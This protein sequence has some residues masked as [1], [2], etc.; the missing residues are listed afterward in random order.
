MRKLLVLC[1]FLGVASAVQAETVH[2]VSDTLLTALRAGAGDRFKIVKMVPAGSAVTVLQVDEKSGYS[3]VR[4]S[5]GARGWILTR[6]LMDTPS[7]RQSLPA[8]QQD[9]ERTKAENARL[10]QEI[11]KLAPGEGDIVSRY[12]QLLQENER[13]SQ[14]LARLRKLT[15]SNL[16][17]DEQNRV[18]QERVV[19]LERELQIAQQERQ[20]LVDSRQNTLFL[21]GAGVLL[22]G[23]ILGWILPGRSVARSHPWGEL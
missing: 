9:L 22:A 13:L 14:E 10:Q 12:N 23:L 3:L 2:Y 17:L 5:E 8:L 18:L 7:A 6:E 1:L 19:N 4:T 16:N 21:L 20:A 11:A 15:T